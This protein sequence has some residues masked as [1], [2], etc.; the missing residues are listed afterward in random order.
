MKRDHEE[1]ADLIARVRQFCSSVG[2]EPLRV[3]DTAGRSVDDRLLLNV[4]Q[5]E[6]ACELM[7]TEVTFA[8]LLLK[9]E[10]EPER[11]RMRAD[12]EQRLAVAL[13]GLEGLL[14]QARGSKVAFELAGQVGR[15]VA[16]RRNAWE[17]RAKN[18][19]AQGDD[20]RAAVKAE[21][22]RLRAEGVAERSLS[23]KIALALK[24]RV[25]TVRDYRK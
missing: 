13:A 17:K 6:A 7:S 12:S 5:M 22:A 24:L 20:T 15:V 8:A 23:Q 1:I 10:D 21:E 16:Q 14:H 25:N 18:L 4:P 11:E 3:R 9:A 2:K 19:K